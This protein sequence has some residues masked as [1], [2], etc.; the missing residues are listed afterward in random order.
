MRFLILANGSY[1]EQDWYRSQPAYDRIICVDGGGKWA[2]EFGLTP[3][4]I[5]GDMDSIGPAELKRLEEGG[6]RK[7]QFET[8][9]DFT[10]TQL[11]MRLAEKEGALAITLW[12]AAGTRLDHT[13][14]NLFSAADLV[15]RGIAVRFESPGESI[16]IIKEPFVVDGSPGET[17]SLLVIGDKA[18]V[19]LQGFKYPLNHTELLS[20]WQWAVSN[21]IEEENP[22]VILESGLLAVIHYRQLPD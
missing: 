17:V 20:E 8:E 15:K 22:T 14:S 3:D 10:D 7:V 9:K 18:I 13:I 19:T 11:A 12:G 5:V 6:A 21:I 2:L 4:W 1:G 16:D